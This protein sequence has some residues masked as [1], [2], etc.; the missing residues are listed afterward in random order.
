LS[1]DTGT[2]TGTV[3]VHRTMSLDGFI[4]GPDHAMEW[5]FGYLAPDE[6]PEMIRATGAILAGRRT[7]EVGRRDAG[8]ASGE[9][10][11]GAWSGP[12]FVLTH[13]PPENPPVPAVTFLSGDIEA[14]VATARKAAGG[15]NLEIFGADVAGQALQRGL[16]DE[17][18]VHIVPVLLG[19]GTLFSS[20]GLPRIDLEPVSTTRSGP[21]T[22]LR[23][24]VRK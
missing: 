14:A 5:V 16:V 13:Q 20:P 7:Y 22:T 1:S 4:S 8:Q 18:V 24:R 10:Y 3:I 2:G 19:G 15:K 9:V 21:V 23:F 6:F 17:I 11:G 12:Q